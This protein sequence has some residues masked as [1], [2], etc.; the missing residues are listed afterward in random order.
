MDLEELKAYCLAKPGAYEDCPF[1]ESP[2]CYKVDGRIFAQVYRDGRVTL[3]CDAAQAQTDRAA[4]PQAVSQTGN[5][6]WALWNTVRWDELPPE[7]RTAMV[8]HS[9]NHVFGHL[10]KWQQASIL[11]P[12]PEAEATRRW[13]RRARKK[14]E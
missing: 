2:L 11:S 1:G 12:Q 7:A 8:D 6:Q 14:S 3:K 9:Y 10:P 4:F 13:K 5:A